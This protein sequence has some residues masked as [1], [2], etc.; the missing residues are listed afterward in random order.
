MSRADRSRM[1]TVWWAHWP[2]VAAE[3]TGSTRVGRPAIVLEAN[4][5][6]ACSPA[7]GA[8]G[9]AVGQ[10]RRVAQQRCPEAVL[11]DHDPD[12]DARQFDPVVRA[13]NE[14]TP[15]LEIVEPGWLCVEARG[16][17]RYYGGDERLS[18]R[19]TRVYGLL[20]RARVLSASGDAEAASAAE[21]AATTNRAR[22]AAA[23]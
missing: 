12:R 20:Q 16:P 7:A 13:V 2:V 21:Q 23:S 18:E 3:T 22:F 8:V 10:R 15:R 19:E 9:V 4:R 11:L 6:V 17:S 5:V 1:L 14:L